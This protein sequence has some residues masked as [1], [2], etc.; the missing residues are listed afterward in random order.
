MDGSTLIADDEYLNE[1]IIDPNARIVEG[2][3]SGVMPQNFGQQFAS[4]DQIADII[5]FIESLK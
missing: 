3:T 4:P 1:S 5:A 2:F